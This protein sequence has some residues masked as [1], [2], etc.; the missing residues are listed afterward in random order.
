MSPESNNS[1]WVQREIDYADVQGCQ[2]MPVLLR[3]EPREAVPFALAGSQF[4]DIRTHYQVGMQTLISRCYD[5]MQKTRGVT[6][7]HRRVVAGK[8]SSRRVLMLV[9]GGVAMFM[10]V[11]A[12]L[13]GM[14]ILPPLDPTPTPTLT[15]TL[16]TTT[17]AIV[18]PSNTPTAT[19]PTATYTASPTIPTATLTHTP[20]ATVTF[21]PSPSPTPSGELQLRYNSNT[22]VVYNRTD[23]A[24][25]ILGL[26]FV[27]IAESGTERYVFDAREWGEADNR[28]LT[29]QCVQVW[30]TE[31]SELPITLP[32]ATVCEARTA[33][34][35]TIREF[36]IADWENAVFEVRRFG[37]LLTACPAVNP[38]SNVSERC[39]VDV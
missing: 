14:G 11:F 39:I 6:V 22:L 33:Y 16:T 4:I 3:G 5:Y 32:P 13:L 35:S 36:W 12:L 8:L 38:N 28:L 7:E 34:K 23:E 17:V 1:K 30:R 29:H 19:V 31:F 25:T 18:A 20:T 21:T 37:I 24:A 26:E 27:L 9:A 10:G 2:I 15:A